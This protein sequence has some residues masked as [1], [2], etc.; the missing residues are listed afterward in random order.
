ML[1]A[2]IASLT[3]EVD[4]AQAKAA[5]AERRGAMTAAA[6]AV[7]RT[8]F[9]RHA[10]DAYLDGVTDPEAKRLRRKAWD[11]T[12]TAI[13]QQSLRELRTATTAADRDR[14]AAADALADATKV[15]AELDATR[16]ALERTIK[17]RVI[18]ERAMSRSGT[19][20]RRAAMTSTPTRAPRHVRV[21]GSQAEL[22]QRYRFGPGGVPEG[23]VATGQV[24]VGKASWYGPGFDGRSTASGAIF[25][26]EGWTVAHKTLPLGTILLISY[27]GRSVVALVND[28]GP[29]VAGRIL[30]LSH[31]VANA[32]GT[33]HSGVATVRAEILAPA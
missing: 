21:T 12:L 14:A 16:Q 3:D 8:R 33:L 1:V 27:N 9:A 31:G 25:D 23:L 2:R 20:A 19:A 29:Y 7:V 15:R 5:D 26:Q 28:R 30:D 32:L 22:M 17:A 13:D 11:S 6:L 18:Y 10:V 4:R 24:M